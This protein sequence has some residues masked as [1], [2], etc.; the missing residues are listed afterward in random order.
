[1]FTTVHP[2]RKHLR[3]NVTPDLHLTYSKNGGILGLVLNDKKWNFSI[4]S[5]IHFREQGTKTSLPDGSI[6][7]QTNRV[8]DPCSVI[9]L[10]QQFFKIIQ[11]GSTDRYS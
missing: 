9:R 5:Y 2:L 10:S 11:A 6:F 1:M 4:K 3:T 8:N 7:R